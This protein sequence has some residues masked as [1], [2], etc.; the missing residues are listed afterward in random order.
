M[1]YILL[2]SCN[3]FLCFE[4][5]QQCKNGFKFVWLCLKIHFIFMVYNCSKM[6]NF[7]NSGVH[8]ICGT[9][10][11]QLKLH[12]SHHYRPTKHGLVF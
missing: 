5:P 9:C 3:K 4:V 11:G 10:I 12:S 7:K 1:Y 6:M 8:G 2:E